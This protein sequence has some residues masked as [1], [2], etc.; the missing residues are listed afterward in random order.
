M[1][2]PSEDR[3][4]PTSQ[5]V[6]Q[7]LTQDVSYGFQVLQTK[8]LT[9]QCPSTNSHSKALTGFPFK[10][11]PMID[12]CSMLEAEIQKP[13]YSERGWAAADGQP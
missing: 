11:A 12:S 10:K 6:F 5:R 3:H 7:D 13:S 9:E 1:K 2:R 8:S 4:S